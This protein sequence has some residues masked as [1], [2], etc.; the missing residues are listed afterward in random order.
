VSL[1]PGKAGDPTG[2]ESLGC[3]AASPPI[4]RHGEG[5]DDKN[6]IF[7][8]RPIYYDGLIGTEQSP[9]TICCGHFK[10]MLYSKV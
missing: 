8:G 5:N 1:A 10:S 6:R 4:R 7:L 3:A 9:A 2:K